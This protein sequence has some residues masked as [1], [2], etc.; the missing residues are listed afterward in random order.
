MIMRKILA[1]IVE[2][3]EEYRYYARA[4]VYLSVL[5]MIYFYLTFI[6]IWIVL[7]LLNFF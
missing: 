4:F 7:S 5:L 2:N 3:N 1:K 6:F